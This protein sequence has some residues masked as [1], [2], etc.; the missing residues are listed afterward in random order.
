MIEAFEDRAYDMEVERMGGGVEPVAPG[1]LE[2]AKKA[3]A[4]RAK[5]KPRLKTK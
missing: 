1:A 5:R 3:S 4:D 2:R